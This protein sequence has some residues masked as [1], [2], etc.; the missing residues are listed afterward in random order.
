MDKF[1]IN[2]NT[3]DQKIN[4]K[5]A[6]LLKDV[7]D[8]VVKVAFDVVRFTD[9]N[10]NIDGLWQI[11]HS[12][13]GEYIVAMYDEG[14]SEKTSA[15]TTLLDKRG[16]NINVFYKNT[17]IAKVAASSLNISKEEIPFVCSYLPESLDRNDKLASALLSSLPVDVK[18]VIKKSHPELSQHIKYAGVAYVKLAPGKSYPKPEDQSTTFRVMR[19]LGNENFSTAK[20]AGILVITVKSPVDTNVEVD[21][22]TIEN[23]I[24]KGLPGIKY[25]VTTSAS[26]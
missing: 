20:E 13:D 21:K 22:N 23:M 4:K 11:K 9:T 26:L 7:K 12:D 16:E 24:Q 10:D 18:T 6:Y 8:K 3:L 17:P 25:A 14:P 15:W 1:T 5:K 2:F 19:L